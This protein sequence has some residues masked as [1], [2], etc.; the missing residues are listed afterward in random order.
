[1]LTVCSLKALLTY[2]EHN[3]VSNI[4]NTHFTNCSVLELSSLPA[5]VSH[6]YTHTH[7]YH[8]HRIDSL[9][10]WQGIKHATL[11]VSD[12]THCH[13]SLAV[14]Q[15]R[16]YLISAKNCHPGQGIY[17]ISQK[18]P[19]EQG[20]YQITQKLPWVGNIFNQF[21]FHL[22]THKSQLSTHP[23]CTPYTALP[24]IKKSPL[25]QVRE[26]CLNITLTCKLKWFLPHNLSQALFKDYNNFVLHFM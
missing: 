8:P 12:S 1:M 18:L 3:R 2:T 14:T 7:K 21:S 9:S 20:I 6:T 10:L 26:E 13:I 5:K 4:R 17:S 16:G 22:Y 19:P 25:I 11:S 15:I 24:Q 23:Y